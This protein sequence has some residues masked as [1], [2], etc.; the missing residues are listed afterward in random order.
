VNHPQSPVGYISSGAELHAYAVERARFGAIPPTVAIV[1]NAK[2]SSPTIC[3]ML[4][5]GLVIWRT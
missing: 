4:N 1:R 3:A 5:Y 2:M